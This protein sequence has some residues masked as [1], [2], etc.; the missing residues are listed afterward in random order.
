MK[1]LLASTIRARLVGLIGKRDFDGILVLVPCNDVH[2][3]AMRRAL[4]IAF[5][6]SDG[7]VVEAHRAV[8]PNHRLRNRKA[9]ATLE[10]FASDGEWYVPGDCVEIIKGAV[11]VDGSR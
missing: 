4:D 5:V 8:P 10:R 9:I 1:A 3:F 6:A 11:P 2:T 7:T